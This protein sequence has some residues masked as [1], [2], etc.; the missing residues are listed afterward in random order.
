MLGK[1]LPALLLCI[2][3]R[4]LGQD[5][6]GTV[7]TC[8]EAT[9]GVGTLRGRLVADSA[10]I[11][12]DR[13]V[14]LNDMICFLPADSAGRFTFRGL[15]PGTYTVSVG[16]LGVRRVSPIGVRVG[17]DSVT[18]VE[19]HLRPENLV[20]DCQE[21]PTCRAAIAPVDSAQRRALSDDDQLLEAAARTAVGLAGPSDSG[22]DRHPGALCI[23]L[24][25]GPGDSVGKLPPQVL[26]A[27]QLRVPIAHQ[28]SACRAVRDSLGFSYRL[29]DGTWAWRLRV[30]TDRSSATLASA[31]LSYH[32]GLLWAGGWFCRFERTAQGWQPVFCRSTWVS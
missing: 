25:Q 2:A 19:I 27:L 6:P 7:V 13:M 23:G 5:A 4:L 15:A 21:V 28:A 8:G 20:L 30:A 17:P 24:G 18:T 26:A 32:V 11:W 16:D 29:A 22:Q 10:G 3:A 9:Q 14:A 1:L 12:L 31:N